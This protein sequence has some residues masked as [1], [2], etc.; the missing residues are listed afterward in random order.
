MAGS[1][2]IRTILLVLAFWFAGAGLAAAQLPTPG[3]GSGSEPS[4]P[5][6][7]W[8]PVERLNPGLGPEPPGLDRSTPMG[9]MESFLG[10]VRDGRLGDAAHLLDLARVPVDRQAGRGPV[11]ARKLGTLIETHVWLDWGELPDRPDALIEGGA[12]DAPRAGERRRSIVIGE[13]EVD[14]HE[15][16]LRLRRVKPA[17]AEPVWVF[18]PQS[19]ARIDALYAEHDPG[20]VQLWLPDDWTRQSGLS[21]QR[22]E[23][24]ALPMVLVVSVLAFFGLRVLFGWLARQA[25]FRP[26]SD[27][28]LAARTPLA[29]LAVA[30]PLFWATTSLI[31]F[32]APVAV[33]LTP[34]MIGIM[35]LAVTIAL[36]RGLDRAINTL[37]RRLVG[38]P[39]SEY[40]EHQRQLYTTIYAVR[41]IL[42][43]AAFVVGL[44]V[45]LTQL[46]AFEA[47]GISLLASAGVLTVILGIAAQP[48]LGN[49]LSSLQ[50]ALAKPIR[51]GDAVEY[52]GR[53]AYV[54]AIF[55]TFVRL[56]TWDDRRLV[57]PVQ[58][59]TS[60]PFENYSMVER[61]MTRVF[62]LTLD[63][64]AD[65]DELRRAYLGIARADEDVLEKEPLKV[66][67]V[68]HD[69][70]GMVVRFYCTAKDAT[71]AWNMH[72]R[73]REQTLAWVR[74]HHPE[75]WP[76]LRELQENR[77]LPP[78]G[79][80]DAAE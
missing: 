36:L 17:G 80:L 29:L 63:P 14:G 54:E 34:V 20:W 74:D 43:L 23:F 4:G 15:V 27:A 60:H 48:I 77:A 31:T 52:E 30:V 58:Y 26:L 67:V 69:H 79:R 66:L 28:L 8:F 61:K 47:V 37:A 72:C 6:Q 44:G 25:P 78:G 32:S 19:V 1:A 38:D 12:G 64:C 21:L 75:W 9:W 57:V 62:L 10:A 50:I 76:R 39:T 3:G 33:V 56:R 11:L 18:A 7:A 59:F 42:L 49:I 65:V 68:G 13:L 70:N 51:I 5:S 24:A 55:Y 73:L 71:T 16:P 45:V 2:L 41:R 46:Q 53:W 22:W 35:V 40:N